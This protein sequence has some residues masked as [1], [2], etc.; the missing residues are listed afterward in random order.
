[1]GHKNQSKKQGQLRKDQKT[2]LQVEE[3]ARSTLLVTQNKDN[4]K[5]LKLEK[6]KGPL[7]ILV[8][9]ERIQKP[10]MPRPAISHK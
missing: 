4:S 3:K 10:L 8:D 6:L 9:A 2:N 5:L 1:M 7:S